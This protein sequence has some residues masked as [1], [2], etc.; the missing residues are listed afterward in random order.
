VDRR[1]IAA[2][3][4]TCCT[5]RTMATAAEAHPRPRAGAVRSFENDRELLANGIASGLGNTG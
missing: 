4:A 5:V 2:A 1:S 3:H